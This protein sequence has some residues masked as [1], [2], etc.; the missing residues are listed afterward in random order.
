MP[1]PPLPPDEADRLAALESFCVLDTPDE[2]EFDD[3]TRLAAA[4]CDVPIALVSL[5]DRDRQWF[6]SRV[7][8][9][10]QQTPRNVA[11]CASAILGNEVFVVSNTLKDPRFRENPLVTGPPDIRFYAGAPII[12]RGGRKVGTVCVIDTKPRTLS[13]R[14]RLVLES[15]ARSAADL[16]ENRATVSRLHEELDDREAVERTLRAEL[17]PAGGALPR[18]FTRAELR[19]SPLS[20]FFMVL[21]AL[22]L[23]SSTVALYRSEQRRI[24]AE[25][26]FQFERNAAF[27]T[28]AILRRVDDYSQLLQSGR[29]FFNVSGGEV[30][31]GRWKEFVESLDVSNR[32]PGI[33]GAGFIQFVPASERE[34]FLSHARAEHPLFAIRPEGARSDYFVIRYVEPERVNGQAVGLD[35]GSE[36][37]RR[38]AA[39]RADQLDHAAMTDPIVLVQDRD[40][41]PGFLM[42]LPVRRAGRSLAGWTYIAVRYEDFFR[43]LRATHS[44]EIA[45]TVTSKSAPSLIYRSGQADHRSKAVIRHPLNLLGSTVELEFRPTEGM[46]AGAERREPLLIGVAGTLLTIFVVVVLWFF[47]TTR[48]R[49]LVLAASMTKAFRRGERNLSDMVESIA[50]GVITIDADSRVKTFS[51]AA[52]EIFGYESRD[53]QGKQLSFLLPE[54][55]PEMSSARTPELVALRSDGTQRIVELSW[56]QLQQE[57]NVA[58]VVIARD[59]TE[60]RRGEREMQI[61]QTFA[62]NASRAADEDEL[63]ETALAEICSYVECPLGEVWLPLGDRL[64]RARSW[65]HETDALLSFDAFSE[66][67]S[68]E[69]GE[70]L[71]GLAWASGQP[72]SLSSLH[73]AVFRR[74]EAAEKA[75]LNSGFAIPVI[76]DTKVVAVLSF[77][78][79]EPDT[80]PDQRHL[81]VVG[82]IAAQLADAMRS[83]R[84][85]AALRESEERYRDLFENASDLIQ[86]VSPEGRFLYVNDAWLRVLGYRRE[87]LGSMSIFDIIHPDEK[88]HCQ[89]LFERLMGGDSLGRIETRF[90]TSDGDSRIVEGTVSCRSAGGQI[91][92]T[93]SIFRDV[94]EERMAQQAVAESRDRL[95]AVL[96]GAAEVSIIALDRSGVITL[97]NRGSPASPFPTVP[98]R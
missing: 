40:G 93:R 53:V 98:I 21:A 86:S 69:R 79:G 56:G 94:T 70:G 44:D 47:A 26:H 61:V 64:V 12:T 39:I 50:D 7:G 63:L 48:A 85:E 33:T 62:L 66:T 23:I 57:T 96:D 29:A 88:E 8:L 9:D 18:R 22:L 42:L 3:L 81:K 17:A 76:A 73:D 11:F 75:G 90:V 49:A 91:L 68:F 14:E 34:S 2:P 80:Q 95:R 43:S 52:S 13:P 89:E 36:A 5:I 20:L 35:I 15:L 6:K 54:F 59:V 87:Q 58:T 45:L 83:K 37:V 10:V 74:I 92:S 72:V 1:A 28:E 4:A 97:F 19:P 71:P 27:T 77:F 55:R 65:H 67:L 78:R 84:A 51:R 30:S 60:K 16:L 38:A 82:T 41:K 31:A 46:F 25:Y 32:Y 24:H